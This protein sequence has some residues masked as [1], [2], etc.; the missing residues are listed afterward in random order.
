[1][2]PL[3][4]KVYGNFGFATAVV[5]HN[6]NDSLQ[7]D[8]HLSTC[9]SHSLRAVQKNPLPGGPDNGFCESF[10]E[11]YGIIRPGSFKLST[12]RRSNRDIIRIPVALIM[13]TITRFILLTLAFLS[14][15]ICLYK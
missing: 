13:P 14:S 8:F 7:I 12:R 4:S 10:Q 5:A 1:M 9:F 15:Y 11:N 3:H 6:Y 2:F